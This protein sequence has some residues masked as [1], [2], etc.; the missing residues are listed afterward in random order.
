M[1]TDLCTRRGDA[2][3]AGG[4]SPARRGPAP[5]V[6]QGQRDY[7]RPRET[8]E[9]PVVRLITQRQQAAPRKNAAS[10]ARAMVSG[11][12]MVAPES[13]GVER[14]VERIAGNPLVLGAAVA[15]SCG[16]G[17]GGGPEAREHA[18][19]KRKV[20]LA[21]HCRHPHRTSAPQPRR[22][23]RACRDQKL[24]LV[25]A[26]SL[27]PLDSPD[28]YKAVPRRVLGLDGQIRSR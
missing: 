3:R 19:C 14:V 18:S 20:E 12:R 16:I 23:A 1:C 10:A 5:H 9:T 25:C 2:G 22:G 28:A 27:R 26:N 8:A 11:S 17:A 6:R 13:S 4:D 21:R 7:G 15:L 24:V